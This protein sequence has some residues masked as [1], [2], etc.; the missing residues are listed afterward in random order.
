[1]SSEKSTS[2][3]DETNHIES[4]EKGGKDN[5]LNG[6]AIVDPDTQPSWDTREEKRIVRK[7][8]MRLLPVLA[9]IYSFALIDRV[10]LPNARI[11]GMDEDLGLSIGN[12]YTLIT[13]IFFVPYVIFQFPANI[14]IRK[15][16]A[17]LWLSSLVVAWGIVCIGIGFN[18]NW[19]ETMGC[20]VLLGILEAGYYPGCIFLLSCWYLR[21]EVQKRFSA[22]YLLALLSSGFSNILAYGLSQMEG[23]GGLNGWRWI[24]IMEGIITCV[25]GFLGYLFIVD[26]PD[27]STRPRLILKKPFLTQSEATIVLARINHDR[28]DAV[29]DSLTAKK[30]L[31]YLA[32]WKLWEYAWLYLLNNTVTYSFGFFLPIILRGDMGYSTTMSQVL[33]FPPYVAA[34][35]WMF[36]TAW[37]ADHY[38][39]RGAI[40]I[41]NCAAAVVG[42]AIMGF[43]TSSPAARYAGVFLGVCGA[44]SN[45]PTI[46]SYMHNNIVGQMKRSVASALII[47]GGAIGGIVA[48]NIFRQQD[49]PRYTPAMATVIATQVVSILHVLKNFWVY[50]RKSRKAER[51]E[52][53][54]EG[55][56]GFRQTL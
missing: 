34:A 8:D 21:Y 51:G 52:I 11:A 49:A 6:A 36:F 13:M 7:I 29:V 27:K 38:R 31:H 50:S 1:M 40:L 54:L 56:Q 17:C 35:P 39:I 53:I 37:V 24:F 4:L 30:V 12:R 43:A 20:R 48:S 41:F 23:V 33:S 3:R 19:T 16:G 26:F 25:L 15:L 28:G 42:V 55:Q 22:F 44:N 46:L 10:N 5:G 45:V 47:G 32:D 14:V 2:S 9:T 18:N